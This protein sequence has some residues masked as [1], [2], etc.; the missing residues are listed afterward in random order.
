MTR[1]TQK[2]PHLFPFCVRMVVLQI[3]KYQNIEILRSLSWLYCKDKTCDLGTKNLP[4]TI[5]NFSMKYIWYLTTILTGTVCS[6]L[7]G[8]T[9][10]MYWRAVLLSV[11]CFSPV[12]LGNY[13][14]PGSNTYKQSISCQWPPEIVSTVDPLLNLPASG[15]ACVLHPL[16]AHWALWGNH[17]LISAT[18]VIKDLLRVASVQLFKVPQLLRCNGPQT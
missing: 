10:I 12:G 4:P 18:K 16:I 17:V 15:Q 7:V 11:N 8:T 13:S 14:A 5:Y 1:L 6:S 9:W 2:H 3:S